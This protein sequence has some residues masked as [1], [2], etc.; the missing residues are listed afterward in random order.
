MTSPARLLPGGYL[1]MTDIL[2]DPAIVQ[3]VG[4]MIASKYS[5]YTC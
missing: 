3:K 5:Q 2:G 1:Y 4:R